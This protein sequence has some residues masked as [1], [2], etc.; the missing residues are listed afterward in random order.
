MAA[1]VPPPAADEPYEIVEQRKVWEFVKR[2]DAHRDV[3]AEYLKDVERL[4]GRPVND[5]MQADE[6]LERF[7]LTAGPEYDDELIAL[8]HRW[9]I[10]QARTLI[11]G[12]A[13]L[14]MFGSNWPRLSKLIA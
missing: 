9:S 5:W 12:L 11:D 6:E 7:V 10:A 2:M 4:L 1:R 3:E 14:P 13:H 8:F